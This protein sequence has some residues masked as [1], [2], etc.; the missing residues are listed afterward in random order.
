MAQPRKARNAKPGGTIAP[1]FCERENVSIHKGRAGEA[2]AGLSC[3]DGG[4]VE[5]RGEE[6]GDGVKAYQL[7]IDEFIHALNAALF[8]DAIHLWQIRHKH[9]KCK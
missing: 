5:L 8:D 9:A 1:W 7:R 4:H 3:A 2:G 6:M